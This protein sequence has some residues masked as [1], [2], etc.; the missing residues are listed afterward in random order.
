VGSSYGEPEDA[1]SFAFIST[2]IEID[3]QE[4]VSA[5]S[6]ISSVYFHWQGNKPLACMVTA[7]LKKYLRCLKS[8]KA[9]SKVRSDIIDLRSSSEEAIIIMSST[10][11][12]I[13]AIWLVLW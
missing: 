10:Y 11:S 8:F 1:L 6:M 12:K 7:M 2:C 4:V 5:L 13:Y 3:L 9:N